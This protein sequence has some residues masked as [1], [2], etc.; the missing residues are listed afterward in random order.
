MPF[1]VVVAVIL[2]GAGVNFGRVA[3]G[4]NAGV[5]EAS[6]ATASAAKEPPS[7]EQLAALSDGV[8]TEGE[9]R[10]ALDRAAD[11]L[12][13]HGL[14]AVRAGHPQLEG[15]LV[16]MRFIPEGEDPAKGEADMRLCSEQHSAHVTS[17]YRAQL[18]AAGLLNEPT[19]PALR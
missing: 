6:A 13:E 4:P 16:L 3:F 14:H 5:V 17:A 9:V 1:S 11:C 2:V 19:P 15:N 18:R 12:E 7:S 8:V 10:Q